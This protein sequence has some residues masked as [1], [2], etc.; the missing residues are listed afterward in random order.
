MLIDQY[1]KNIPTDLVL[2]PNIEMLTNDEIKLVVNATWYNVM[3][4]YDGVEFLCC[5]A[6]AIDSISDESF[7]EYLD[8]IDQITEVLRVSDV[9]KQWSIEDGFYRA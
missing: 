2:L 5:S 6:K 1:D 7:D 3:C 8:S 9:L 4:M